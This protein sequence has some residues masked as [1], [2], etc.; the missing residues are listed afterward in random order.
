[1]G[2]DGNDGGPP[3]HATLRVAA[4]R[5]IAGGACIVPSA[6]PPH[7]TCNDAGNGVGLRAVGK[8]YYSKGVNMICDVNG[9]VFNLR[10]VAWVG[11]VVGDQFEARFEVMTA[12]GIMAMRYGPDGPK[13]ARRNPEQDARNDRDMLAKAL[14]QQSKDDTLAAARR[15]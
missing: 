4:P 10:A 3:C 9:Y 6:V 5:I 2:R 12:G 7:G 14:E 1:M 8:R 15:S 11:P 13:G